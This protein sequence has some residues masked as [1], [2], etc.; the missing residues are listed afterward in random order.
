[1]PR[2]RRKIFVLILFVL[3]A[4][5][6]FS[7]QG[8]Q[9]ERCS[10]PEAKQLDFWLGNWALT[11]V[12]KE[13]HEMKGSN[14]ISK[15]FGGCVVKEEFTDANNKYAGM[16]VSVYDSVAGMWKQTWVDNDG[17]YLDFT[18]EMKNGMMSF[19]RTAWHNGKEILQR[20][21]WDNVAQD[22]LDWIWE[23]SED[24]GKTW[25][26]GWKIHYERKI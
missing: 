18:G 10:R 12:D 19:H 21:R 26:V 2:A 9:R 20:M 1:M 17:A 5:P 8:I 6:V 22:S 25:L 7:Q 23:R 24:N 4:F 11:W 16:S 14:H 13:G 15:D 3:F